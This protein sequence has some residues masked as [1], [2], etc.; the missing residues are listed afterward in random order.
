[1]ELINKVD[2]RNVAIDALKGLGILLMVIGHSHLPFNLRGLIFVF[3]MP[4]FFMV[5]GYLYKERS[6]AE[7]LNKQIARIM[8]P[9]FFTGIVIW[10]GK[11]IK[12]FPDW[13]ISLILGNGSRPV[14]DYAVL[15]K[16]SIG[17]L[18]Y[19]LAFSWAILFF[20]LLIR[21]NSNIWKVVIAIILF[22]LSL[23]FCASFGP[24]PLDILQ[25]IPATLFMLAGFWYQKHEAHR[26]HNKWIFYLISLSLLLI[27]YRYGTLSMASHV[28]KLNIV[29]VMAAIGINVCLYDVIWKHSDAQLVKLGG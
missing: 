22:E 6:Y 14:F 23:V 29:Q 5:S 10:I 7:I 15:E 2:N 18:W 20:R 12:G 25:A 16:Y 24:L 21:V 11:L 8:V 9:F 3:H 19:L 28:Y 4:L 1:M 17:P 13:G 27:C 26:F